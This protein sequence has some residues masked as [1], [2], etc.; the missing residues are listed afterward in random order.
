M[1]HAYKILVGKH[2]GKRRTGRQMRSCEGVQVCGCKL[3]SSGSRQSSWRILVNIII[4]HW[5]PY[6]RTDVI[7]CAAVG[8]STK[9]HSMELK[10]QLIY[11]L[12]NG[13]TL[14][15][16]KNRKVSKRSP[17]KKKDKLSVR[18][19]NKNNSVYL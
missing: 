19:N 10:I 3:G 12:H 15:K 4:N 6:K 13:Q 16:K 17:K 9:L 8:L 11:A 14:K 7:T 1:R 5:L 18:S 2:E